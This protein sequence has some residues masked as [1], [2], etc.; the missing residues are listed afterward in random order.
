MDLEITIALLQ[1]L[2]TMKMMKIST[3]RYNLGY[4]VNN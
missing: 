2:T 4:T 3:N 1:E